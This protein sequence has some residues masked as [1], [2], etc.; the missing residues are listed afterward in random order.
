[1]QFRELK[2]IRCFPYQPT[3][4][5][6]ELASIERTTGQ[7]FIFNSVYSEVTASSCAPLGGDLQNH[8]KLS[9]RHYDTSMLEVCV[10]SRPHHDGTNHREHVNCSIPSWGL[11]R[12]RPIVNRRGEG[13]SCLGRTSCTRSRLTDRCTTRCLDGDNDKHARVII[14]IDQGRWTKGE[15]MPRR[16]SAKHAGGTTADWQKKKH[17]HGHNV[18]PN[19]NLRKCRASACDRC[20]GVGPSSILTTS[21]G[22]R[23]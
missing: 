4:L 6:P 20:A 8:N 12:F 10:S 7:L 15:K 14:P 17:M 16:A 1:M 5:Q 11:P 21:S 18:T 13:G 2:R 22:R 3:S 19:Y 23:A 9:T